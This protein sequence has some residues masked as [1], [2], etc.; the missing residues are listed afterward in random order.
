VRAKFSLPMSLQTARHLVKGTPLRLQIAVAAAR[1]TNRR[2]DAG[3]T[4]RTAS[5]AALDRTS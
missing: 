5:D 1:I 3:P 4:L 2:P